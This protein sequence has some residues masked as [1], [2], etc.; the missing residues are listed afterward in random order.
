MVSD[1]VYRGQNAV[2][3]LRGLERGCRIRLRQLEAPTLTA[4]GTDDVYFDVRWSRW[5]AETIPGT[6]RRR[7]LATIGRC[8]ALGAD[9]AVNQLPRSIAH[10]ASRTSS[11]HWGLSPSLR[12]RP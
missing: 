2:G 7:E 1:R 11:G 10:G 12:P 3:K 6:R 5:L 4:W 8:Y 9:S